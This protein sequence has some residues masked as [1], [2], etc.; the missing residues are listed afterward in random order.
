MSELT[1][2][3]LKTMACDAEDDAERRRIMHAIYVKG[4]ADGL[5]MSVDQL[6]DRLDTVSRL[7]ALLRP[8]I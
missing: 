2:E 7:P 8:Q 4:L 3:E 5:Q 6:R 1:L